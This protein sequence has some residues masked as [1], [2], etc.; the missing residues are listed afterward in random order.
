MRYTSGMATETPRGLTLK[1][2]QVAGFQGTIQ[3]AA[4]TLTIGRAADNDVVLEGDGFPS[5]STHHASL[6]WRGKE[7]WVTDLG[8][9]N[10]IVVNGETVQEVRLMAGDVLRLGPIGPRFLVAAQGG[11][12]EE[13]AYVDASKVRP[14]LAAAGRSEARMRKLVDTRSRRF[15]VVAIA[16][17]LLLIGALAAFEWSLVRQRNALDRDRDAELAQAQEIIAEL[18]QRQGDKDRELAAAETDREAREA[19]LRDELRRLSKSRDELAGRL[20]QVEGQGEFGKA[21][22]EQIATLR[23]ELTGARSDLDAARRQVDL[24]DPVNLEASRLSKVAA[25]REAVV[26]IESSASIAMREGGEVLHVDETP[27]GPDPNFEGR[28]EPWTIDSTGS[29]FCVSAD[30]WILTNAHVVAAPEDDPLVN[31]LAEFDTE[32]RMT[33]HAVFSGTDVRHPLRVEAIA[34]NDKDLALVHIEPFEGMPSLSAFTTQG[35]R[36]TPGT[37]VFLFGFP[38]GKYAL[39][40]GERVIAS[41]F[42]G[43][44]SRRVDGVLQVD[45]G[46]HP[47]NSGGPITDAA[48][49]VIGVV[50]SVQALPDRT[51]VFTIG[52]GV[53]I[54]DASVLWPPPERPS[55]PFEPA[56]SQSE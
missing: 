28:G 12:L 38:L 43:I 34:S 20:A 19:A 24:L 29:G 27:F 36:P 53:P 25:V 39:Q 56:P 35:R 42:R 52:Y 3:L 46:V 13:T 14:E 51:A 7:L 16:L 54:E 10:G 26:L 5:V 32:V 45:A 15:L 49:R 8:S 41:T 37:D 11:R 1:P 22:S 21:N 55:R 47:G 2:L 31:S 6:E 40:E 18:S 4:S 50:F 33:Y 9:K 17:M 23:E 48:G 30:G 44:L